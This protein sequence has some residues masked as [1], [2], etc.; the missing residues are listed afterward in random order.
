[1]PSGDPTRVKSNAAPVS[2]S[3]YPE[4]PVPAQPD[5]VPSVESRDV[6]LREADKRPTIDLFL[7]F[8]IS[9]AQS[10]YDPATSP[11]T[12][13]LQDDSG[14]LPP[15]SPATMDQYIA[16]DGDL[17]LGDPSDL[18]LLSSL[19]SLPLLPVPV[20]DVS[21]PVSVVTPSV[22]EPVL[23]PSV[24]PPDLSQEGPFDVDWTASGSGPLPGC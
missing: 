20:A 18:P 17:L 14:F 10:Y 19:L 8:F 9:P 2:P 12:S 13:D 23:V 11:I 22:G 4:P 24:V 15:D 6:P 3:L 1:M 16:A 21:G 5:P 7:S